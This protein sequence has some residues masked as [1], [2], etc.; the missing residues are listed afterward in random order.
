M[1]YYLRVTKSERLK[2]SYDIVQLE[3][4]LKVESMITGSLIIN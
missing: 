1:W 2:A 4:R 3:R